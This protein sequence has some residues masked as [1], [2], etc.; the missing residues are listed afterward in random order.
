[1]GAQLL[2]SRAFPALAALLI[3]AEHAAGRSRS[4]GVFHHLGTRYRFEESILGRVSVFDIHGHGLVSGE[5]LCLLIG[6]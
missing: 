2:D 6:D 5:P 1:M 4:G 3:A